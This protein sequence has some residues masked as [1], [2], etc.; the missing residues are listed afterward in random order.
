LIFDW[1]LLKVHRTLN[2]RTVH[3]QTVITSHDS[4]KNKAIKSS[5]MS[6]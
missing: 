4:I 6:Q 2:K 5:Y 3:A 1:S